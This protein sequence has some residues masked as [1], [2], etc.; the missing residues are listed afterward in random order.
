MKSEECEAGYRSLE[1][2]K[3][4]RELVTEI[5]KMTLTLP[6]FELYEEGCQIRRS[7]KRVKACIVEGYGRRI[8]KADYLRFIVFALAS[9]DET[10]DHLE[11][12]YETKSLIDESV[13]QKIHQKVN[14]LGKKLNN[15]YKSVELNHQPIL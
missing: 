6:R 7:S 9:N 11:T 2:W 1:V 14:L 15:F 4:A 13:Y 3:L 12:L 8:Y 10:R 5:H